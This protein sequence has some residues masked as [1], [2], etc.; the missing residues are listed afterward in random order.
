M[1]IAS[2]TTLE[3]TTSTAAGA[4]LQSGLKYAN[5]LLAQRTS[6]FETDEGLV[7]F[8]NAALKATMSAEQ[9]AQL[10]A[11]L[12][13]EYEAPN[14]E[15]RETASNVAAQLAMAAMALYSSMQV[16]VQAPL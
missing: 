6:V 14:D 2:Q 1:T 12:V 7:E 11:A 10:I 8:D 15:I 16:Q 13:T 5:D 4:S 3:N 9:I